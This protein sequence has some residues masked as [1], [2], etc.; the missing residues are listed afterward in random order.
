MPSIALGR[1]AGWC[2]GSDMPAASCSGTA[3]AK[4]GARPGDS[5]SRPTGP[6]SIS[7]ACD[8]IS[9][10]WSVVCQR[11]PTR[12]TSSVNAS[13]RSRDIQARSVSRRLVASTSS[14]IGS[15]PPRSVSATSRACAVEVGLE[16]GAPQLERRVARGAPSTGATSNVVTTVTRVPSFMAGSVYR[17]G[18]PDPG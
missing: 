15:R 9:Q 17:R 16:V 5:S 7:A 6:S 11:S 18:P 13:S 10:P 3:I 4:A 14:E 1:R 8:R 12:S 2:C